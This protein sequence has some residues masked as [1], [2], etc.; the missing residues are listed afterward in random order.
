MAADNTVDITINQK[1]SF[2]VLFNITDGGSALDLSNYTTSAK[3][4]TDYNA[5][6]AQSI[7]FITAVANAVG[8]QASMSLTP[9]QTANLSLT[10]YFYDFTITN[11]ATGFKTRVVEGAV[12]VSGGVS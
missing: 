12:K 3:M 8:G 6:D 9:A 10:R 1:S 2:Y 11:T 5:S 4:K 7:S